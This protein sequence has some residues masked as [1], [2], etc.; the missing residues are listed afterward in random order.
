[1]DSLSLVLV[2]TPSPEGTEFDVARSALFAALPN[3][4]TRAPRDPPEAAR[5]TVFRARELIQRDMTVRKKRR[6][7]DLRPFSRRELQAGFET[8]GE[9]GALWIEDVP[10]LAA[11]WV[12][13]P[14]P[15]ADLPLG[16][17]FDAEPLEPATE[18]Q[19]L[20]AWLDSLAEEP[21]NLVVFVQRGEGPRKVAQGQYSEQLVIEPAPQ[22]SAP[23]VRL[24]GIPLQ[25][26]QLDST[27]YQAT[28]RGGRRVDAWLRGK[29]IYKDTGWAS[30]YVLLHVAGELARHPN[31]ETA[32][33]ALVA[34]LTGGVLM[35]TS[36]I[37]TPQADIRAWEGIPEAW[38]MAA[39]HAPAR[40]RG[41]SIDGQHV[42]VDVPKHGVQFVFVPA[43][44]PPVP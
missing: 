13:A 40:T 36:A 24:D 5:A 19:A 21:P 6:A 43:E 37:S 34:G 3:G 2:N 12:A 14:E 30:G 15:S 32:V 28:T 33:V 27:S 1:M 22:P 23:D 31:E 10:P 7:V 42:D 39:T 8:V 9:L 17:P 38:Y 29:A 18:A 4:V 16:L 41:L 20:G 25:A 44:G 11:E 35:V 26:H